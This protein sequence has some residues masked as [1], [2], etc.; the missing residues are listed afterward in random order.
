MSTKPVPATIANPVIMSRPSDYAYI[1]PLTVRRRPG[2]N[3]RFDFGEINELA[4]SIKSQGMLQA[5]LVKR[6]DKPEGDIHFELVDGDRR[7]TAVEQLLKAGHKF[8]KGIPAHIQVKGTDDRQAR[9]NMFVA[10]TGKPFLPLE[11]AAVYKELLDGGMSVAEM[12]AAVGRSVQHIEYTMGLLDADDSVKAALVDGTLSAT[13][14]K[15][16]AKRAKGDKGAQRDIVV[17]AKEAKKAGG[18]KAAKKVVKQKVRE[19]Q[20]AQGR[21]LKMRALTDE[22]LSELGAKVAKQL[23]EVLSDA[24][25]TDEQLMSEV[26]TDNKLA[27]A[28]SLGAIKALRAAAGVKEVLTV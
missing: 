19:H 25:L 10:N 7:F 16:I 26:S 22:Q 21:K 17:A 13:D 20:E 2:W 14:A 15:E 4:N 6:L 27:A 23:A 3:K 1:D 11:E 28:F 8:D 9:I 18:K 12:A 24:G 5:I